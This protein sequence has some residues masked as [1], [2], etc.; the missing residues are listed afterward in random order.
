MR[1]EKFLQRVK[2]LLASGGPIPMVVFL[3]KAKEGLSNSGVVEDELIIEV[4]K[5]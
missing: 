5:V 1:Q 2:G 4:Y 3:S